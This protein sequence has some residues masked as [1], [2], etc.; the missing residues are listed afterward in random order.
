LPV[1]PITIAFLTSFPA[2]AR[3]ARARRGET[4]PAAA[5][6]RAA[7]SLS[8]ADPAR[9]STIH[10]PKTLPADA[11]ADVVIWF[12]ASFVAVPALSRV[13]PA[14][15]SG[16]TS[17]R[18]TRSAMRARPGRRLQVTRIVRAPRRRAPSSAPRTKGVTELAETPMTRSPSRTAPALRAPA[19]RSSSAPSRARNTAPAAT[20]D[21]GAHAARIR[22]EGRRQL[23]RL[24][25]GEPAGRAGAEEED[26]PPRGVG[27]AKRFGGSGD[28][29]PRAAQ[30]REDPAVL[31]LHE[32]D[33]PLGTEAIEGR[34]PRVRTLGCEPLPRGSVRA[35]PIETV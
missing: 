16:P 19:R 8:F 5:T 29:G 7:R 15:T 6:I 20:R 4:P 11:S 35:R 3:S 2:F 17:R 18:T 26:V 9:K 33:D 12:K 27:L 14:S 1:R 13:E 23:R 25:H 34:R 30:G 31:R 32:R 24:E 21:D 22:P 10:G 28:R